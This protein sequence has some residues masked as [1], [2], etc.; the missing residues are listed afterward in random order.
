MRNQILA[1][2]SALENQTMALQRHRT[3]FG[4]RP[5]K[6]KALSYPRLAKALLGLLEAS[7]G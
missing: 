5:K 6:R 4:A 1:E 7:D 3:R 2:L